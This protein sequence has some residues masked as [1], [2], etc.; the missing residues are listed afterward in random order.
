MLRTQ[1]AFFSLTK[2]WMDADLS[3]GLSS[4]PRPFRAHHKTQ[5]ARWWE[6]ESPALFEGAYVCLTGA[7]SPGCH[8]RSFFLG[9]KWG[10]GKF[11]IILTV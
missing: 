10:L 11:A 7:T 6:L 9:G 8:L 5:R 3:V 1:T 2:S 4:A